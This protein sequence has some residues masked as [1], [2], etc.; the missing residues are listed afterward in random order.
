MEHTTKSLRK[1]NLLED[2]YF[3]Q[4]MQLVWAYY[5]EL[6]P[7]EA[8]ELEVYQNFSQ[9]L[10]FLEQ[11]VAIYTKTYSMHGIANTNAPVSHPDRHTVVHLRV[12]LMNSFNTLVDTIETCALKDSDENDRCA[13]DQFIIAIKEAYEDIRNTPEST[14][15]CSDCHKTCKLCETC[16]LRSQC[17]RH[18]QE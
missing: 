6:A 7:K 15:Q 18:K 3:L 8:L 5:Q 1:V 17:I 11:A 9:H 10:T 14:V 13:C 4:Y 12:Q 16:A 2:S